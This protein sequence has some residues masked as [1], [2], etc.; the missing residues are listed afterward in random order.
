[1]DYSTVIDYLTETIGASISGLG[2]A[3]EK[4][5][6]AKEARMCDFF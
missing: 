3:D 4:V 2:E 6:K 5:N 1:M